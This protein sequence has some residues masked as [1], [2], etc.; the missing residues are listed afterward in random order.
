MKHSRTLFIE[1][2]CCAFYPGRSDVTTKPA[3]TNSGSTLMIVATLAS[4]VIFILSVF[5]LQDIY[6][7][8]PRIVAQQW[9][10]YDQ[11]L[12]AFSVLGLVFG[13]L[14]TSLVLSKKSWRAAVTFGIICTMSGLGAFIVTLIQPLAVL[15]ESI[16][17]FFLPLFVAPLAGTLM[18]YLH[19]ED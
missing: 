13:A 19:G 5:A 11:L 17:F 14:T 3:Q 15:W 4:A 1:P 6:R 9:F 7:W 2:P 18:I 10:I 8:Y 16:V 12:T